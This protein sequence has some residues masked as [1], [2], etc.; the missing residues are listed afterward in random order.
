MTVTADQITIVIAAIAAIG[1]YFANKNARI[2]A[3]ISERNKQ[4][5][6]ENSKQIEVVRVDVNSKMAE[7][8]R[9]SVAAALAEGKVQG[10][11]QQKAEEAGERRV[12]AHSPI[13][14]LA[15]PPPLPVEITK[16][17]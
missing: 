17:P 2:A 12:P 1:T 15:S 16:L 8:V 10:I 6:E 5:S 7:L 3:V 4:I 9:T 11:I 13:I 14:P